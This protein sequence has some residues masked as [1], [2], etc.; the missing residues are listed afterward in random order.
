MMKLLV[1]REDNVVVTVYC[2]EKDG[3]VEATHIKTEVPQSVDAA[4]Q[5]VDFTFRKPSYSDSNL[6]IRN[7]NFT[8]AGEETSINV[9]AFQEQVLRSLL[10]EWTLEDSDGKKLQVNTANINNLLPA[11]ARASISG[12][13]EKIR[14]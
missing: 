1:T 5:K 13:L 9:N 11:V 7:A 2:Y 10:V 14:I 12:A 3:E 6:I 8:S 4:V